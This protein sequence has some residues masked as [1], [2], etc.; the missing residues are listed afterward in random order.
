MGKARH[1]GANA[2]SFASAPRLSRRLTIVA[3][4]RGL[5]PFSR[6]GQDERLLRCASVG[7]LDGCT[8][9]SGYPVGLLRKPASEEAV[10]DDR[11]WVLE[12]D[13][14]R[15]YISGESCHRPGST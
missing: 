8:P 2:T 5:R 6:Q 12:P 13:D 10:I 15:Q 3:Q 14:Y 9:P 11:R 4:E 1:Y 7:G